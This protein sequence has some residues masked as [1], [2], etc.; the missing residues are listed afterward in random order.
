MKA[1]ILD[2]GKIVVGD[3]PDVE[4]A[5]G[6]VLVRTLR[7]ALCASDQHFMCS[8]HEIIAQSDLYGGA[9]SGIDLDRPLVMGHEFVA[10]ILDYGPGSHRPLSIGAKVTSIPAMMAGGRFGII[11]YHNHTPGGLA[12][13]MLLDENLMMPVPSDMDDDH[14]AL[15]EPLAVGLEHA[16]AGEPVKG[17]VPLV[18]GCG[19]IGLGVIAGLKLA[20]ISPIIAA[21]LDPGRRALAIQ[22]GADIAIDPREVSPYEAFAG[23]GAKRPNL[24]YEC[25]GKTGLLNQMILGVQ[26][27]ARI[28]MGGFALEPE[29]L[30]VGPA[31]TKKL[32]IYFAGGEEPQD[33]QLARDAIYE[34]RIDIRP[35]L[36]ERI[37]LNAV[38]DALDNLSDPSRPV[39]TTVDPD[40]P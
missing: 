36:G 21:D 40:L 27:G 2:K 10:E 33:M 22:S 28:V 8:G 32:R 6:Q 14:A 9:Y 38:A 31:Q 37:G 16:R 39:R 34:R 35:W 23:L 26:D 13:C 18:I 19:A 20:G 7:C 1:A 15:I 17:D 4:P 5:Q 11:G 12:Q 3:F 29:S 30:F 25:V 24:V